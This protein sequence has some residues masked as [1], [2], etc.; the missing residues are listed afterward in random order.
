[1]EKEVYCPLCNS[2]ATVAR[3]S[4]FN[5]AGYECE[6]CG[7]FVINGWDLEKIDKDLFASYFFYNDDLISESD[8]NAIIFYFIGTQET[9]D[10]LKE[11]YPKARLLTIEE[12]EN[13]YPKSFNEKIDTILLGLS[14]LSSFIGSE[15]TLSN[16]QFFSLFFVQRNNINGEKTQSNLL[17][18]KKFFLDYLSS[19]NYIKNLTANSLMLL[20]EGWQRIDELQ[21]NLSNSKQA[22]I[23]IAFSDDMKEVQ[24]EIEKGIRMAGYFSHVM[25]KE[26]HNNQIVP[27][28]LYQIKQSKFVVAEFSTSNN[29]AYYEAGYA[30]GLGKQVI[31][32]CNSDKFKEEGHFDIKQ[33]ST[34]LWDKI[35]KIAY[36]LCEHI[37]ATIS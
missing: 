37:K 23:A 34:I 6:T 35:E 8:T 28:I 27:E 11:Q 16:E 29:G 32:I 17:L 12:V 24:E 22:F 36:D 2:K 15:I 25:N 14:K 26:K 18:Q 19:Q 33:K 21:K 7:N 9:F 4:N 5:L 31:H 30:A 10:R 1:M 13:W 3:V 20:P